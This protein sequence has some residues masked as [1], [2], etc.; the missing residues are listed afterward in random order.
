M[1]QLRGLVEMS[2]TTSTILVSC[3]DEEGHN[4]CAP[5]VSDFHSFIWNLV[6]ISVLRAQLFPAGEPS[7]VIRAFHSHS[8]GL[9]WSAFG[10]CQIYKLQSQSCSLNLNQNL[11]Q[12]ELG[13]LPQPHKSKDGHAASQFFNPTS[14]TTLVSLMNTYVSRK[15]WL[16]VHI[17]CEMMQKWQTEASPK[18]SPTQSKITPSCCQLVNSC[19]FFP[20]L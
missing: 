3:S 5:H 8:L 16:A 2:G 1:V 6:Q 7:K 13:I 9:V 4:I 11:N 12:I 18:K 10:L 19:F 20:P 14:H 15:Q 17:L